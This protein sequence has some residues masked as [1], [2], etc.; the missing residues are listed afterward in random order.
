MVCDFSYKFGITVTGKA[1]IAIKKLNADI[2][3]GLTT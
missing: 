3:L 1:N 2:E